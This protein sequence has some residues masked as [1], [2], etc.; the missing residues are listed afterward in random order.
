MYLPSDLCEQEG[1]LPEDILQGRN[2]AGVTSVAYAVACHAKVRGRSSF[3]TGRSA[4]TQGTQK[5]CM[6]GPPSVRLLFLWRH[7]GLQ[8]LHADM[9]CT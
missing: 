4:G 1:V 3:C 5:G 2:Q 6:K 7:P 9:V 8:R